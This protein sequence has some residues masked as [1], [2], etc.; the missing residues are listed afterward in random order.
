MPLMTVVETD[1]AVQNN[2]SRSGLERKVQGMVQ[3]HSNGV[4]ELKR[5]ASDSLKDQHNDH[6]TALATMQLEITRVKTGTQKSLR[7]SVSAFSPRFSF[8]SWFWLPGVLTWFNIILLTVA[9]A[10]ATLP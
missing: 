9:P 7:C 8:M 1:E 10:Y 2:E 5:Q 3:S 6:A 4:H